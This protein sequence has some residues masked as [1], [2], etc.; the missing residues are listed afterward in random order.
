MADVT[1]LKQSRDGAPVLRDRL[2]PDDGAAHRRG[3]LE[4][5]LRRSIISRL[6]L[7]HP[8]QTPPGRFLAPQGMDTDS[9]QVRVLMGILR[10]DSQADVDRSVEWLI[11]E[12]CSVEELLIDVIPAIETRLHAASLADSGDHADV[13]LALWRLQ[14]LVERLGLRAG[15]TPP[16]PRHARRVLLA[17]GEPALFRLRL[18]IAAEVL[19]RDGWEVATLGEATL[20]ALP[21]IIAAETYALLVLASEKTSVESLAGLIR[22]SR[23]RSG[24][25]DLKVLIVSAALAARPDRLVRL[26]A[27]AAASDLRSA[28]LQTSR[29]LTLMPPQG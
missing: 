19:D 21:D 27:D 15:Q 29:L 13:T 26:G 2:A 6:C 4:D 16:L 7:A 18:Q 14:E 24:N 11:E 25:P 17:T 20:S 3:I 28:R 9:D 5:V 12:G 22:Q 1:R 10:H 8:D 23:R